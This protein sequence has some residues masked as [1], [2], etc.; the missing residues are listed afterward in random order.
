[1]DE[2]SDSQTPPGVITADNAIELKRQLGAE[3]L[4]LPTASADPGI[5]VVD[6]HAEIAGGQLHHDRVE[7]RA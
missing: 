1:M 5:D 3:A 2:R 7:R 4:W 6:Q